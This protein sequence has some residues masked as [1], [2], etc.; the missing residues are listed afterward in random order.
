MMM[1][2]TMI[3]NTYKLYCNVFIDFLV[4]ISDKTVVSIIVLLGTIL[5]LTERNNLAAL[6]HASPYHHKKE[7]KVLLIRTKL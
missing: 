6:V 2:M 1:V 3:H 4:L 5:V 7:F